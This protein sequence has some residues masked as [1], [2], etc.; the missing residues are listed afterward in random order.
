MEKPNRPNIY[1]RKIQKIVALTS[2][3]RP[4]QIQ[5]RS[6]ILFFIFYYLIICMTH[7]NSESEDELPLLAA[8]ALSLEVVQFKSK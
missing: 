5:R 2:V 8:V 7:S 6:V 1:V 4:G 3:V